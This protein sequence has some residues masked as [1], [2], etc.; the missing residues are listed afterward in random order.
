MSTFVI[1]PYDLHCASVQPHFVKRCSP[2]RGIYYASVKS[3]INHIKVHLKS[4]SPTDVIPKEKK[5]PVRVAARHQ[6]EMMGIL[7]N[8]LNNDSVE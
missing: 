8:H 1:P 6:Q 2:V 3:A 7:R 4:G 5:R